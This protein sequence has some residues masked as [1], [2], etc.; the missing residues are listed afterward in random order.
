MQNV[1][2]RV[3]NILGLDRN[4]ALSNI[5]INQIIFGLKNLICII[6]YL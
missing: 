6:T 3:S 2:A 5:L 1:I 4:L